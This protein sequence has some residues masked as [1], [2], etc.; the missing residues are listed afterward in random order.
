MRI[1]LCTIGSTG[2][3]Q[4]FLALAQA[5]IARNHQVIACTNAFYRQRFE[6]L[7]AEFRAIGPDATWE[8]VRAPLQRIIATQNPMTQFTILAQEMFENPATAYQ[9]LLPALRGAELAVVHFLDAMA[10][11]AAQELDI[12]WVQVRFES[13]GIPTA[14]Q[15]ALHQG[16]LGK[17]LNRLSWKIGEWYWKGQERRL[18]RDWMQ[19][20]PT[21]PTPNLMRSFSPTLNLLAASQAI[22]PS[23][24]DFPRNLVQTGAWFLEEPEYVPAPA[25]V[26]FLARHPRPLLATFGSMGAQDGQRV[27]ELLVAAARAAKR[28]LLIQEGFSRFTLPEADDVHVTGYAPHAWLF[29]QVSAVIHHGGAGTS[30]AACRAG[31]PSI[32]APHLLDQFGW[33]RVLH[34]R[35]LAPSPVPRA[36]LHAGALATAIRQVYAEPGFAIRAREVAAYMATEPG[37]TLAVELLEGLG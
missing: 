13:G 7:G 30:S 4:P 3:I 11:V 21:A 37:V 5:L 25:L 29:R 14:H 19:A 33:A 23:Y 8:R 24:P 18:F 20:N 31:V 6:A 26:D 2:D 15:L 35:G 1:A 36:R 32:V 17:P 12:P 28:P 16:S 27:A 22:A 10:A 34:R 9:D